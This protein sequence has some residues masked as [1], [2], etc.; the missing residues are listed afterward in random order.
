MI[1]EGRTENQRKIKRRPNT[2]G[3]KGDFDSE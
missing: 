3:I 1:G 2:I